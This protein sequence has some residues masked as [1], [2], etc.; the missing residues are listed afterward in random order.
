MD[1]NLTVES[2]MEL[3]N[4]ELLPSIRKEIIAEVHIIKTN[5]DALND[6][7]MNIEKSQPF[8]SDK[9]DQVIQS[10]QNTKKQIRITESN[11]K[12]QDDAI[13]S[14]Q[15]GIDELFGMMDELQQY[16]RRDCLEIT[17]IP[18]LPNE[19]PNNLI[20]EVGALVGVEINSDD[21]SIAHRLPD[22]KNGKD[23]IIV[24]FLRR[25]KKDDIYKIRKKLT[26]KT[27]K[28]LPSVTAMIEE[29]DIQSKRIFINESLTPYRRK[30]LGMI[31]TFKKEN[32]FKFLWTVNGKIFL[33]EQET[34]NTLGPIT[35]EADFDKFTSK[36]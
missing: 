23:R 29:T 17:G 25:G 12:K 16:S 5:L 27:I 4:N 35:N 28:D 10:L 6:R 11:I 36:L 1:K 19:Q 18:K 20:S 32:N 3:W 31:N 30:L 15:E 14:N 8:L 13:Y 22:S 7:C 21:I 33:K 9:Y 26:K 2:F 34:S 24:K